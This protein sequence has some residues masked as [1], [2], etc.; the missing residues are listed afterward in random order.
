MLIDQLPPL[1][2]ISGES[3]LEWERL[4]CPLGGQISMEVWGWEDARRGFLA[5][6]SAYRNQN[7][8]TLNDYLQGDGGVWALCGAPG[9]GKS[10]AIRQWLDGLSLR[11]PETVWLAVTPSALE[12]EGRFDQLIRHPVFT[13]AQQLGKRVVLIIDGFDQ[14]RIGGGPP[15]GSLALCLSNLSDRSNLRL[16]IG[17]RARDW[18]QNSANALLKLWPQRTDQPTVLEICPLTRQ[19][20]HAALVPRAKIRAD[21]FMQELQESRLEASAHWPF[22]LRALLESYEAVGNLSEQMGK[23]VSRS[24]DVLLRDDQKSLPGHDPTQAEQL[25]QC[26]RR[27]AALLLLSGRQGV[28]RANSATPEL[29][30]SEEFTG[31]SE[32][33]CERNGSLSF[34]VTGGNLHQLCGTALMAVIRQPSIGEPQPPMG[35]THQSYAEIL[36]SEYLKDLDTEQLRGLLTV[37]SPGGERVPAQLVEVASWL[38]TM[39]TQWFE[40]LLE[41][42][43]EILLRS[44][45]TQY[46]DAEKRRLMEALLIRTARWDAAA[47]NEVRLL[48]PSFAFPSLSDCL[49]PYITASQ[50][51]E[52][53][54]RFAIQ[55]VEQCRLAELEE[56]LWRLLERADHTEP[57]YFATSALAKIL[58]ARELSPTSIERLKRAMKGEMGPDDDDDLKGAA[59]MCLVPHELKPRKIVPWLT[60]AKNS[61]YYGVYKRFLNDILPEHLTKD[62]LEAFLQIGGATPSIFHVRFTAQDLPRAVLRLFASQH[63]PTPAM[64]TAFTSWVLRCVRSHSAMPLTSRDYDIEYPT[65]DVS[66]FVDEETRRGWLKIVVEHCTSEQHHAYSILRA[67]HLLPIS[68]DWV[69]GQLSDSSP[70]HRSIWVEMSRFLVADP[71]KRAAHLDFLLDTYERIPELRNALGPCNEGLNI[72]ETYLAKAQEYV[73]QE[74]QETRREKR[75]REKQLSRKEWVER[76][77]NE[78]REGND[79]AWINLWRGC[80]LREEGG[81]FEWGGDF[82]SDWEG[83]KSLAP[84]QKAEISACARAFLVRQD[85]PHRF[86]DEWKATNWSEAAAYGVGLL[87]DSLASD[88]ELSVAVGEKWGAVWLRH[89]LNVSD[90]T[91]ATAAILYSLNPTAV[92]R[93]MRD[94]FVR[95]NEAD[96]YCRSIPLLKNCWNSELSALFSEWLCDEGMKPVTLRTGIEFLVERDSESTLRLVET[97]LQRIEENELSAGVMD[98]VTFCALVHTKGALFERVFPRLTRPADARRILFLGDYGFGNPGQ[99]LASTLNALTTSQLG[100]LVVVMAHA[101]PEEGDGDDEPVDEVVVE[102]PSGEELERR[103]ELRTHNV[104]A[105]NSL[106][107]VSDLVMNKFAMVAS[108]EELESVRLQIPHSRRLDLPFARSSALKHVAQSEWHPM[109]PAHLLRLV[110]KPHARFIRSNDDLLEFVMRRLKA[111]AAQTWSVAFKPLWNEPY[112]RPPTAKEEEELSNRLKIWLD[113]DLQLIVNREVQP[114]ELIG[115]RLDLKVEIPGEPRLCVIVEVKKAENAEVETAMQTQL[116]DTYLIAGQQT[117]GIYAVGWFG[118]NSAVLKGGSLEGMWSTLNTLRANLKIPNTARVEPLLMDFRHP[119][120]LKVKKKRVPRSNYKN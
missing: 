45:G 4:W 110:Q 30:S 67:L 38:A 2:S 108:P 55:V 78:W 69:L 79:L 115:N 10:G 100:R 18:D 109:V 102:A 84:D 106:Y 41:T 14:F 8:R 83:W 118:D 119:N 54:K 105:A 82:L 16:I 72:H 86:S 22:S 32:L 13:E 94:F 56:E 12:G 50:A 39:H 27:L 66:F 44:D 111:F 64:K 80:V 62:D 46:S 73:E 61:S 65:G 53:A 20:V 95:E 59:L 116:V 101:F 107:R 36:A 37:S 58:R 75:R 104:T 71:G 5:E 77:L 76:F 70:E 63:S 23:R 51:P 43:P 68:L 103:S 33:A 81:Y 117:H 96:S 47:L 90:K 97:W 29:L 7:C 87:T 120:A 26:A 40:L 17:C 49:R 93:V 24:I 98:A 89:F 60:L 28:S 85:D 34:S 88:G 52:L 99:G 112:G 3:L 114:V 35:F 11:E 74:N 113:C 91:Q 48:T 57:R 19:Q 21:R 92:H 15:F 1:T 31:T 42:M 25:R 9:S 6:P